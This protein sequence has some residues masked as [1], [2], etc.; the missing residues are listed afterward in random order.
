MSGPVD[1]ASV[2]LSALMCAPSH[3][4]VRYSI[5]PWM[6][7]NRAVDSARADQQWRSLVTALGRRGVHIK[8]IDQDPTQPDM[9]FTANAGLVHGRRVV[10]SRFASHERRGEEPR[11]AD[12]FASRGYEVMEVAEAFE[13]AGDASLFR[14]HVI[15]GWGWR[16]TRAGVEAAAELLGM[17]CV[18]LRLTDPR[19]YHL[20]TCLSILDSET[21]LWYPAA[22]DVDAGRALQALCPHL[23]PIVEPEALQLACNAVTSGRAVYTTGASPRL[24][25]SLAAA[26]FELHGLVLDEFL[27]AGGGARCLTLPLETYRDESGRTGVV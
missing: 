13:G 5:N 23:I 3:F 26:G 20:D 7:P 27:K 8:L 21:I 17:P 4:T 19:F 16:S 25:C 1:G 2:V 12:W 18:P 14:D 9:V 22:F 6:D 10:L 15:A 24:R 11:F